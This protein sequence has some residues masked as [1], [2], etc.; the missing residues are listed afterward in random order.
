MQ[1]GRFT[2]HKVTEVDR[3]FESCRLDMTDNAIATA[4]TE[5]NRQEKF[6][7]VVLTKR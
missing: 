5:K 4:R 2:V 3:R 1:T 7:S 6:I